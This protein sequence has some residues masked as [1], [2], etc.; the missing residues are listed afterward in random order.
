MVVSAIMEVTT[1]GSIKKTARLI[2]LWSRETTLR[3]A[4]RPV[5]ILLQQS[6][7]LLNSV[8]INNKNVEFQD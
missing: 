1:Y 6:V 4:Q 5:N 8:P 3:P 2:Y 7:F